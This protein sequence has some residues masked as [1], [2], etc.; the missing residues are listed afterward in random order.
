MA[1]LLDRLLRREANVSLVQYR[2]L[3]HLRAGAP[4]AA[5]P[6]EIAAALRLS[7][8]G[9]VAPTLRG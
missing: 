4:A 1:G 8:D 2:V 3:S 9:R 5:E 7:G 6:W